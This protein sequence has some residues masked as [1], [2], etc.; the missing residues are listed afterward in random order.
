MNLS[1]PCID[2]FFCRY[3]TH[4]AQE[5]EARCE[6]CDGLLYCWSP[7]CNNSMATNLQRF[8]L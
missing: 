1:N 8:S 2:S 7:L 5:P 4:T 6:T 3:D